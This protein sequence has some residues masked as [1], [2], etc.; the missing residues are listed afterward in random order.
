MKYNG[1][2][3]VSPAYFISYHGLDFSADMATE[4]LPEISRLGFG[5]VQ[6]EV[7]RE[8]YLASWINGGGSRFGN[9]AAACGL[10]VRQ[11]V[12]HYLLDLQTAPD[13]PD[14]LDIPS[15]I[16]LAGITQELPGCGVLTIPLAPI[17]T[18]TAADLSDITDYRRTL[19]SLTTFLLSRI[20]RDL[21]IA[22]EPLRGSVIATPAGAA[23]L[24]NTIGDHRAGINL[25]T[26]NLWSQ[27]VEPHRMVDAVGAERILGTHLCDFDGVHAPWP[28][29]SKGPGTGTMD[30]DRFFL[31]LHNA[32]YQG[33]LDVEISVADGSIQEHYVRAL[34]FVNAH[35][36]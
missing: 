4:H 3:G 10:E 26:G 35:T 31:Q 11:L 29:T 9:A 1:K 18:D 23:E 8:K 20:P 12:A 15:L 33:P 6:A 13:W 22:F 5:G 28:N 16:E 36:R 34:Q 2:P 19:A 21:C 7:P 24:L 17:E 27:G 14:L 25:D 30:W 32:R